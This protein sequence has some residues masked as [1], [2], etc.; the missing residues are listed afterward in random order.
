MKSQNAAGFWVTTPADNG[1]AIRFYEREV[2]K[3][4]ETVRHQRLSLDVVRF[5]FQSIGGSDE[6]GWADF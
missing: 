5:D 2:L 6:R 1:R 3:R 4:G